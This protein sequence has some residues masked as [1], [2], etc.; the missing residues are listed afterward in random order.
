MP[1][2]VRYEVVTPHRCTSCDQ[3]IG[4]TSTTRAWLM[5]PADRCNRCEAEI[6]ALMLKALYDDLHVIHVVRDNA[7]Q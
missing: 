5:P 1:K 7:N 6:A 2:T 4:Q 3:I